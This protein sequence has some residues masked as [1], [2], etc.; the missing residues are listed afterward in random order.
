MRTVKAKLTAALS[1]AVDRILWEHWDPI[2][3]ND[4]PAAR[5]EYSSYVP[6]VVRLLQNGADAFKLTKH[7]HSLERASMGIETYPD[8][9]SHVAQLL[10][11]EYRK[12]A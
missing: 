7:L 12:V 6:S 5:N 8:H 11:D 3:L 2:H 9:R 4:N 10:L 1:E